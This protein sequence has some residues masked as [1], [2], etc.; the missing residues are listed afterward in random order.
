[1][2]IDLYT[3]THIYIYTHTHTIDKQNFS[4]FFIINLKFI[5]K[6][7]IKLFFKL[8]NLSKMNNKSIINIS[9]K[10]IGNIGPK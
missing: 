1:M 2:T 9:F 7:Y 6:L 10:K 5:Y 4:L 8:F 3:H